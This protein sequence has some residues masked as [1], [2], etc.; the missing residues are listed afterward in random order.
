MPYFAVKRVDILLREEKM[1]EIEKLEI[2]LQEFLRDFVVQR[3]VRVMAFFQ[4][5]ADRNG[6]LFRIGFGLAAAAATSAAADQTA[7]KAREERRSGFIL[8]K[9][10]LTKSQS[11]A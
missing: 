9:R 1:A 4:E 2:G 7:M 3:L 5:P 8:G 11:S 6:D 10:G